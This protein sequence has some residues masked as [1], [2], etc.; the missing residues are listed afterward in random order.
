MRYRPIDEEPAD[1]R[2]G[3]FIPDDWKHVERHPF[4]A[5]SAEVRPTKVPVVIGVDWYAEF[6]NPAEDE[7]SGEFFVAREG[8][9]SL[10]TIRG[11]HCVC[12]EPGGEPDPD[13]WWDFYDQGAE[14]ACVGFGWSRCMSI[15]NN[16]LYAARWLWDRSKE[17][18]EWPQ[19]NPGDDQGTSVRAA[20][21]ILRGS[22]HV[23]W[24]DELGDD[25][26]NERSGYQPEV[27]DGIASF[28]WATSVDEVHQALANDRADERGAVPFLNSWGRSYP[29]RT[30][31]P[32]EVL[33]KLIT[34]QGEVAIPT[35]RATSSGAVPYPGRLLKHPPVTRGT[36]VQIWQQRMTE[37]GFS[38]SVD[39][40]YG[41]ESKRRCTE[42]QQQQGL[43]A[44]GIVG[45]MTWE[46]TFA[47]S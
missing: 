40:A 14:G 43:S 34:D 25:D 8:A 2:L 37:H 46:R 30:W 35:D 10:S 20:G 36:D 41:P 38:L 23:D 7:G 12:L 16:E 1:S 6:D 27:G 32:D 5:L 42:F 33:A 18:D 9:G 47:P 17:I 19:T 45:P 39:G 29:H 26:H 44:D 22:G 28:A 31:M 21:D 4:G 15:L 13:S 3:R 24:A 11:G